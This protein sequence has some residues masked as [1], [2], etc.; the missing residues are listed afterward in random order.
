ML[1]LILLYWIGKY[2]YKLAEKYNKSKWGFTILGIVSYYGGIVLFSFILGMAAEIIA[3]GYIDSFNETLLGLLMLPFGFLSCY[4][5][6]KYL[7]KAWEKN[8][9]N[10]NKLID[11]IGK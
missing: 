6:Y 10:P 1:G 7:E 4:L 5:L 2:Y 8:K 3:P 9:P 11:E